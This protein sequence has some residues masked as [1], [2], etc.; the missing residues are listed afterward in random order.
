MAPNEEN[1]DD[2]DDWEEDAEPGPNAEDIRD[3]HRYLEDEDSMV[4]EPRVWLYIDGIPE[5]WIKNAGSLL[6]DYEIARAGNQG[7]D[8]DQVVLIRKVLFDSEEPFAAE[9]R[10]VADALS[11]VN[12]STP[13]TLCGRYHGDRRDAPAYQIELTMLPKETT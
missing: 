11:A 7:I 3:V 8:S 10:R 4:F 9:C 1:R 13:W 5:S 6:N 12:V 2:E